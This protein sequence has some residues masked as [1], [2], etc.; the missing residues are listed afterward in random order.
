MQFCYLFA[1]VL[2]CVLVFAVAHFA[3]MRSN[4]HAYSN[5]NIQGIHTAVGIPR[6]SVQTAG[7]QFLDAVYFSLVTQSTVGY[8]SIVPNSPLAKVA[9]GAQVL[10]TL[11]FVV[12]WATLHRI[13]P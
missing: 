2:A 6:N 7:I 3:I 11:F 12:R 13:A 9:A 10:T 5:R 8:G 1:E 4:P